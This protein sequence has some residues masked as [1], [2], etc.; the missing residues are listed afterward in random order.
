MEK[1]MKKVSKS[2]FLGTFLTGCILG[3]MEIFPL[4]GV[5]REVLL[6]EGKDNSESKK[7]ASVSVNFE[8]WKSVFAQSS[9]LSPQDFLCSYEKMLQY[10][11]D[12]KN[13]SSLRK[14]VILGYMNYELGL[15]CPGEAKR[16]LDNPRGHC[17]DQE[18]VFLLEGWAEN[19][20]REAVSY[21]F[22]NREKHTCFRKAFNEIMRNQFQKEPDDVIKVVK[23]EFGF[24]DLLVLIPDFVEKKSLK[25]IYEI[26][27]VEWLTQSPKEARLWISDSPYNYILEE[28]FDKGSTIKWE[29]NKEK[30]NISEV[31]QNVGGM[32]FSELENAIFDIDEQY[33]IL[34]GILPLE[35]LKLSLLCLNLGEKGPA[36]FLEK[37]KGFSLEERIEYDLLNAWGERDS[38][39]AYNYYEKNEKQDSSFRRRSMI[40][41]HFEPE[42]ALSLFLLFP[43]EA[44]KKNRDHFVS[45][46]VRVH[47]DKIDVII[48]LWVNKLGSDENLL[49]IIIGQWANEDWVSAR[50]W[51]ERLNKSQREKML[52]MLFGSV[53]LSEI[54]RE[55]SQLEGEEKKK[56]FAL[57]FPI[58]CSYDSREALKHLIEVINDEGERASFVEQRFSLF[59]PFDRRLLDYVKQI[60]AGAL[61]D[62]ILYKII[63]K[64]TGGLPSERIF[65][66]TTFEKSLL[67]VMDIKSEKKRIETFIC[68]FHLRQTE[69]PDFAA[70]WVRKSNLPC[71]YKEW[72]REICARYK[73]REFYN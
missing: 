65:Y 18:Y 26:L 52:Q 31:F 59:D 11:N 2:L 63:G 56:A 40:L 35:D 61:K 45:K 43:E 58:F 73:K 49:P 30:R 13:A 24:P 71:E 32:S 6:I 55:L 8:D 70:E 25:Q 19:N 69:D 9:V 15:K 67:L 60:P 48:K 37:V 38:E 39:G 68:A 33:E 44:Q 16:I 34:R 10:F 27:L 23:E 46:L 22:K 62:S 21:I 4:K 29:K 50:Q 17:S 53:P 5:E 54:D 36:S 66:G 12:N 42:K 1:S 20:F 41:P 28:R 47:W 51:V 57:M 64:Q 7:E 14:S 3:S 72:M